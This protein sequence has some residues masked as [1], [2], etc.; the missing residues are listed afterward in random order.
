MYRY[1]L[2]YLP[3]SLAYKAC[4]LLPIKLVIVI[5]REVYRARQI[6]TG[7]VYASTKY[8]NSM[9]IIGLYAV[10]LG[11]SVRLSVTLGLYVCMYKYEHVWV[12]VR[13]HQVGPICGAHF[14]NNYCV[15]FNVKTVNSRYF[16]IHM[17]ELSICHISICHISCRI[18][19]SV[20]TSSSKSFV[21]NRN[22]SKTLQESRLSVPA[23][24]SALALEMRC[25][26]LILHHKRGNF[27]FCYILILESHTLI[28][29]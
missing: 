27:L 9:F 12:P 20:A 16:T 10:T 7:F 14:N 6:H 8:P 25:I 2:N 1:L 18:S 3:F 15:Y 24:R 21:I 11:L 26:G 19:R 22:S 17:F 23:G 13:L 28:C 4:N 29:R 5:L